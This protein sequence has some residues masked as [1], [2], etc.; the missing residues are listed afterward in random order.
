V[1]SV[2]LDCISV[3]LEHRSTDLRA[4]S[5]ALLARALEQVEEPKPA[6]GPISAGGGTPASDDCQMPAILRRC[7]P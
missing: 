5:Y 7:P 4:R 1:R 6:T 2:A 3:E